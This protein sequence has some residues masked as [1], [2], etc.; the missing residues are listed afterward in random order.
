MN[1]IT[2]ITEKLKK[3]VLETAKS[4]NLPEEHLEDALQ[5]IL[6]GEPLFRVVGM[7]QEVV[8]ARYTLASQA[9]ET[10]NYKDAEPLFRWLC[11]Y[12]G[13]ATRNW[14]GL[15]GTLQAQEQYEEARNIYQILALMTGLADP[16][17][18]YYS[19]ICF[20][21]EKNVEDAIVAFQAAL[22]IG[23]KTNPNHKTYLDRA[24]ALIKA[25]SENKK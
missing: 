3:I 18:F 13:S 12:E 16:Q 11:M 15:G 25:L 10:Q 19:G 22:T 20:L 6:G 14:L 9:Y 21:K 17:P 24:E 4:L 5:A 1:D 8:E 7:K 2:E 23:D